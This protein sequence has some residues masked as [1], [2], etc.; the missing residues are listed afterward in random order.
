MIFL[1]RCQ[2]CDREIATDHPCVLQI[3]LECMEAMDLMQVDNQKIS[4][5]MVIQ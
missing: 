2:E 1:Y 5:G 3:C 4:G